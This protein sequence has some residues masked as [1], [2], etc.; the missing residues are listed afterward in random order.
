M[1]FVADKF[2]RRKD[3]SF[4]ARVTRAVYVE[5]ANRWDMYFEDGNR[6]RCNEAL[7]CFIHT[8][9][10]RSALDAT[11]ASRLLQTGTG[12]LPRDPVPRLATLPLPNA[13]I[14]A[15][16][17]AFYDAVAPTHRAGR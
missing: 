2:D 14:G 13:T 3:I 5:Q 6:V 16:E 8:F 12:C 7:A 9:D 17:A 4:N 11:V 15:H 1:N 10:P